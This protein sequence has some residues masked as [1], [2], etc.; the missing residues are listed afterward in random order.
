MGIHDTFK[1]KI[2][3]SVWGRWLIQADLD[4]ESHNRGVPIPHRPD[5][6]PVEVMSLAAVADLRDLNLVLELAFRL[7]T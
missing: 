5:D 1:A 3:S 2:D 7:I 6:L 4:A